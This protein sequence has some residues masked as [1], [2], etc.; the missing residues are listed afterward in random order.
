VETDLLKYAQKQV[1]D[2]KAKTLVEAIKN[3]PADMQQKDRDNV[4]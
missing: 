3:A 2:G 4:Q 1:D